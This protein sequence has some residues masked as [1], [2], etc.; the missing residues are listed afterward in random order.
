MAYTH[1][2][3]FT[4]KHMENSTTKNSLIK[5]SFFIRQFIKLNI[6]IDFDEIFNRSVAPQYGA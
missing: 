2:L 3:K 1:F 4:Q 6:S 5:I